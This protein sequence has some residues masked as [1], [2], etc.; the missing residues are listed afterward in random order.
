MAYK[1]HLLDTVSL[2][3][4]L[5]FFDANLW[6]KILKPKFEP[7]GKDE[8]YQT[9]FNR[10]KNSSLNP[11]IAVTSLVLSEVINRIMREYGMRKY[12]SI[13]PEAKTIYN[14]DPQGFYKKYYRNTEN[15]KITY[16]ILC[17]DIKSYS[18][19][20]TLLNDKLGDDIKFK[21]LLSNPPTALDFNDYYYYLLAKKT[22]MSIV[23]DDHD[24][25]VQ[26]VEILT[27]NT[28]L[29]QKVKDMIKPIHLDS[30]KEESIKN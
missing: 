20:C 2:E 13:N 14:E 23:T 15:F 26:D 17:D 18:S 10:F 6:I 21:H 3:K 7:K 22:G 29:Y 28:K 1:I 30:P 9:F 24:F 11:K 8:K 5:Y 25:F 19:I 16:N 12:L 4:K 27:Y